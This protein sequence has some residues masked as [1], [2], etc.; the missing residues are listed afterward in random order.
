M[1]GTIRTLDQAMRTDVHERVRRTAEH[2][3]FDSA[4]SLAGVVVARD[5]GQTADL[6]AGVDREESVE[7]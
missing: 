4:P 2:I 7:I 1:V 6:V 5:D 3:E